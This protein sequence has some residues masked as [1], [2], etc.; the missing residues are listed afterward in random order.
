MVSH[1]V[2]GHTVVQLV[3][4]LHYKPE[5]DGYQSQCCHWNF[6]LTLSFQAH[7]SPGVDSATNRNKYQKYFLGGKGSQCIG[8]TTLWL[9]HADYHEIWEPQL[10]GTLTA[11]PGIALHFFIWYYTSLF[12]K[13]REY[14][15]E[16]YSQ[17][18]VLCTLSCKYWNMTPHSLVLGYG[19]SSE[20][21]VAICHIMWYYVQNIMI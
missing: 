14:S 8:L 7:Y 1:F 19:C 3:E 15:L 16:I 5:G 4:A 2:L 9:S 13:R 18:V 6:S 20:M 11:C 10:P 21:L 17:Y 12:T